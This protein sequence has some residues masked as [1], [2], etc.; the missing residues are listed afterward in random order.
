M[1]HFNQNESVTIGF[2]G[3]SRGAGNTWAALCTAVYL[4]DIRNMKTCF[5]ELS[6]NGDIVSLFGGTQKNGAC[7]THEGLDIY[8]DATVETLISVKNGRYE[9]YVLDL[10]AVPFDNEELLRADIKVLTA[11]VAPWR[12]DIFEAGEKL[13]KSV[14][15]LRSFRF[16]I[17]FFDEK[18]KNELRALPVKTGIMPLENNPFRLGRETIR[19]M[20]SLFF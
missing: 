17:N 9:A 11:C 6:G 3:L 2:A 8:N 5:I 12:P 4:S 18:D 13:K 15:E 19:L 10:G 16:L 1:K 20:R 14:S 7:Y